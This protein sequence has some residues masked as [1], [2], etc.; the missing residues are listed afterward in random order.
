ME[1][2]E[3]ALPAD[4]FVGAAAVADWRVASA[5]SQKLKRGTGAAPSLELVENPDILATVARRKAERPALVVGFAAETRDVVEQAK[6]KLVRKGCDLIVANDVSEAG[7]GFGGATNEVH[8][9]SAAGIEDWPRLDKNLVASRLV[10]RLADL[11]RE[12]KR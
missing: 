9:V 12:P 1:A 3:A 4:I 2:V 11:L 7:G 5:A 8:L 10:E 6:V